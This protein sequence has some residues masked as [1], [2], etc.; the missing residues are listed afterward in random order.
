MSD[1]LLKW[2]NLK[3][4]FVNL[5]LKYIFSYLMHKSLLLLYNIEYN[6]KIYKRN[7]IEFLFS[8]F[9][10]KKINTDL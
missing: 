6:Y 4:K 7:S 3:K 2:N 9:I 8:C 10:K 1:N 5:P